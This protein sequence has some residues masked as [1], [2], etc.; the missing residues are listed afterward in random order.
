MSNTNEASNAVYQ[1]M[2]NWA[3]TVNA[4]N[5]FNDFK[6]RVEQG[7]VRNDGTDTLL[8]EIDKYVLSSSNSP[9]QKT[10]E[11]GTI[12]YR[13]RII[14]PDEIYKPSAIRVHK[15]GDRFITQGYDES[16]SR[17]CLF[18][19]HF[20]VQCFLNPHHT[21]RACCFSLQS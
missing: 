2:L 14:S 19:T 4:Q 15:E 8:R 5:H 16:D 10:I 11:E 21:T 12:L 20:F 17:E 6:R 7:A 18:F 13:A 3:L 9:F 1:R